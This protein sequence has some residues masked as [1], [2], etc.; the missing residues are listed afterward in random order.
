MSTYLDPFSHISSFNF[1]CKQIASFQ[2]HGPNSMAVVNSGFGCL[3]DSH[4]FITG[5]QL[6][7]FGFIQTLPQHTR[8]YFTLNNLDTSWDEPSNWLGINCAKQGDGT[9]GEVINKRQGYQLSHRYE[10]IERAIRCTVTYI[11]HSPIPQSPA[12]DRYINPLWAGPAPGNWNDLSTYLPHLLHIQIE[13]GNA[14][15]FNYPVPA[16]PSQH[17]Y[18]FELNIGLTAEFNQVAP[19]E[20]ASFVFRYFKEN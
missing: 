6:G 4:A 3:G 11:N 9:W 16:N 8:D 7:N 17:A 1:G 13:S 12:Y 10:A 18:D 19:G 15:A 2:I 5:I 20:S 14:S